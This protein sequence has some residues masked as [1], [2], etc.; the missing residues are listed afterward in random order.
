M[1]AEGRHVLMLGDG[2]N[3]AGAL[4]A[5]HVSMA[6]ATALDAA[7]AA[8]DGVLL[9]GDLSVVPLALDLAKQA[10][11]RILQNFGAAAGYNVVCIPIA[12][13]GL[14]SPMAAAIAMSTSSILVVL[15]ALRLKVRA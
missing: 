15:N 10:K 4:A 1:A 3:D 6:P 14:A 13:A 12:M 7:R 5:A 9:G 11:S 2:L 8:A